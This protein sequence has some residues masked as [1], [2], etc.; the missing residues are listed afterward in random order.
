L[1]NAD[2]PDGDFPERLLAVIA[3]PGYGKTTLMRLLTLIFSNQGYR[4]KGAKELI[5]ILLLF[6]GFYGQIQGKN[7]P[8]LPDLILKEVQTI[9]GCA[10]LFTSASWFQNKLLNSKCLVMLDGLDE[11]PEAQRE[12]VSGWAN[13]QMA[14]YPS[15]F[16]LTSRPHGFDSSLFDGVRRVDVL[17]FNDNQKRDFI[18]KWYDLVTWEDIWEP[19]LRRSERESDPQKRLLEE[20]ARI[21]SNAEAKA[22]AADLRKQLFA[23]RSLID[24]A[25]NPLLLTIIAVT[26]KANEQLPRQRVR[27]YRDIFELLLQRRPHRRDT[28]LTIA[29][30]EINQRLLQVIAFK[31]TEKGVTQ[32]SVKQGIEWMQDRFAELCPNSEL[33]PKQFLREIEHISGLL[34]GGDGDLYEFTH[35]TFQE[36]LAA[37]ELT[38]RDHDKQEVLAHFADETWKEVVYFYALLTNPVPFIEKALETPE[39]LHTL[40]LAQR[41]ANDAKS[42]DDTLRQKLLDARQAQAPA[43]ADVLLAQHF[44]NLTLLNEQT[45]ISDCITWGEYQLFIAAQ[46]DKAFHS[47][48]DAER[49]A[50]IEYAPDE[51]LND[52]TWEDARWFCAWLATQAQLAPDEGVYDYRLPTPEEVET[53]KALEAEGSPLAPLDKGGGD[54]RGDLTLWTTNPNRPGNCLRVVR[55]RIPARY[56]ELVN[57]LASGSWKEADQETDKLMLKAAGSEAEKRGYLE[58]EEIRHFPCEDLLLIDQLWVKFSGGKFGFSVQKQI[59]VEVGGKLDFGEDRDAAYVAFQKMS[60][61]NGWRVNGEYISYHHVIFDTLAPEGHLPSVF[62]CMGLSVGDVWGACGRGYSFLIQTCE[63]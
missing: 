51:L 61:R 38:E 43:S 40:E 37:V 57:Y 11:V 26:H 27:L 46:I 3:D 22:A 25:K 17:D 6:R 48:A 9:P 33:T 12:K 13:Y 54:S 23:D 30:P 2:K 58:L 60:D 20:Q 36:Y 16:I 10:D 21:Q 42:I 14:T 52:V 15:Q 31:L 47:W 45:A 7:S 41:I 24:L 34:G 44:Q 39:N 59:W 1:P 35:K 32:F 8:T 29:D 4:N 55:Q 5:P 63:L 19:T 28:K 53:L 18:D 56:R 50:V 49:L 62:R